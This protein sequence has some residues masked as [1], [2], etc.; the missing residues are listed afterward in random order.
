M[1]NNKAS[2]DCD[3]FGAPWLYI[4]MALEMEHAEISSSWFDGAWGFIYI[5]GWLC[6]IVA[7]Q[8]LKAVL[9]KSSCGFWF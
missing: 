8:R 9:E 6:L 5:T 3:L 1:M 4:G 7:L 2:G